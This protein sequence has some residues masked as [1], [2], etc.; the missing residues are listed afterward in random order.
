M[1]V[2]YL[3]GSATKVS[4]YSRV[5]D[6]FLYEKIPD[7]F[8]PFEQ[9]LR[10]V[11]VGGHY[12]RDTF[13]DP[14]DPRSGT[15]F[16]ADV[17]WSSSA[18]G[19]DLDSIR[20]LLTGSAVLSPRSGWS[21]SHRVRVGIAEALKDTTLDPTQ[22]YFAGGQ[23]SMRGFLTDS[24]GPLVPSADGGL[25][26]AGGGAL[27][28]LNEEL[29]VPVWKDLRLALFTD[30]GQVWEDWS[31]ADSE[32]SI[33]VGLG[34]RYSTPIGPLWGDVAWPVANRGISEGPRYYFGI[35]R[36]F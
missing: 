19:S 31:V 4:L 27:F 29:R 26:G 30:V 15:Y 25:V 6:T 18:L 2:S 17:E 9:D 5:S 20:T 33:G 32:L 35:G 16:A 11:S 3:L 28:I 1:E 23:A 8:F 13:D 12:T 7:E 14:F 10:V 21:W 34:F 22:R 36:T 24:V